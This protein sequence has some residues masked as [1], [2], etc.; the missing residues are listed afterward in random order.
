[1]TLS[2]VNGPLDA[3]SRDPDRLTPLLARLPT[4]QASSPDD[5]WS[6][7]D[8]TDLVDIGACARSY[9]VAD[10]EL[11]DAAGSVRSVVMQT[12]VP[13]PDDRR[14]MLVTGSSPVLPL[15]NEMLEI[16]DAITSPLTLVG[17]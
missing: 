7:T 12:F 15:A 6:R 17:V 11:P 10:L 1:M 4:S 2:L 16:F 9:G 3:S 14:I 5:V 8:V 13:L